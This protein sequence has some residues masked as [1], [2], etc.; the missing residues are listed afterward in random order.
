M[1]RKK[2]IHIGKDAKY[3][4]NVKIRS[5]TV[6]SVSERP[7][8]GHKGLFARADARCTVTRCIHLRQCDRIR[9]CMC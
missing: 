9:L 2:K 5:S 8:F 7:I 4:L 1:P 3:S 6:L